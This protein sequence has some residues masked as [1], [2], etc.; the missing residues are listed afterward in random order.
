[1]EISRFS[2][3]PSPEEA[4]AVIA[5]LEQ[6]LRDTAPVTEAPVEPKLSPWTRA[7]LIEGVSRQPELG[8]EH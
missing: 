1:M 6:F 3:Q 2:P 4:A 5:A 8:A 7:A